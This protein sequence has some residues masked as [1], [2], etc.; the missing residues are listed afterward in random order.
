MN[1]TILIGNL[2]RAPEL[3]ATRTG[4]PVCTFTL[5]VNRRFKGEDGKAGVDFIGVVAWRQL[6]ELCVKYLAKGRKAAVVGSVQ[7]R[8]YED[9]EGVR[10]TAVEVVADEVEFL[11]TQAQ[12]GA[13]AGGA[14]ESVDEFAEYNGETPFDEDDDGELPF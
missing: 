1:K 5:A 11:S 8:G 2:T 4:V 7:V 10:R 13:G 3:R 6:G 14:L 12:P 9:R